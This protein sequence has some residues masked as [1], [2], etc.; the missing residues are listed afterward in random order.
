MESI[1]AYL[2]ALRAE[3][4]GCDPAVIQDALADAEEHLRSALDSAREI[5]RDVTETTTMP[6]MVQE[7]GSPE[8]V[9]AAYK[10][11][12]IRDQRA[13]G[14][15]RQPEHRS[16]LA[17]FFG[18]LADH[19]A[20]GAL[21]YLLLSVVTGMAYFLWAVAGLSLSLSLLILSQDTAHQYLSGH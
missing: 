4:A 12:E 21:L 17:R 16:L 6:T 13:F 3:L 1:D 2:N 15:P 9:A 20:W 18:V 11:I 19:R 10:E 7:Y 14:P 5:D 8:E